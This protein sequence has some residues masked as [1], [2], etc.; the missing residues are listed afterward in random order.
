M[1]EEPFATN[2]I[3]HAGHSI[4]IEWTYDPFAC[5]PWEDD[6]GTGIVS[7]W[8]TRSKSPGERILHK[9]RL[10]RRYYDV[11]GTMARATEHGWGLGEE[12]AD[13][14]ARRLGRTPTR[15]EIIAESVEANFKH[16]KAWCDNQWFWCSYTTT[17][18]GFPCFE[19]SCGGIS[20]EDTNYHENQSF[21]YA[22]RYIDNEIASALD[23]A[24]R[25]IP[26]VGE[27]GVTI[28]AALC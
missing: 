22:R 21:A 3:V 13:A 20:S 4:T 25:D 11:E 2:T 6:G 8:T 10:F 17:I 16:L 14:L 7:D 1:H 24:C 19:D 12:A 9:D 18:P 5:A 27:Y 26:T 23:A 28:P 15:G